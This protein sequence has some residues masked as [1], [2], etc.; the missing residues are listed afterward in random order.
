[1][2]ANSVR[3]PN[4]PCEDPSDVSA[5]PAT[6]TA[7]GTVPDEFSRGVPSLGQVVGLH[8]RLGSVP[9]EDIEID[10]LPRDDIPSVLKGPQLI[11]C[12]RGTREELLALLEAHLRSGVDRR[13]GRSGMD[14]WRI[15][16]LAVL[17]QGLGRDFDRQQELANQHLTV[18][19][20]PGRGGD[21][22][23]GFRGGRRLIM[24]SVA[25]LSPELLRRVDRRWW[26]PGT[27][28]QIGLAGRWPRGVTRPWS[29]P[30]SIG[31]PTRTCCGMRSAA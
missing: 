17:K 28:C 3:S 21:A 20:M 9:T 8:S 16:V 1:M 31:Q 23:D 11:R 14:I 30:A 18:R 22:A 4:S 25:L 24:D 7:F 19:E 6:W 13:A 26:G 12:D 2:L 27:P 29:R 15:L 5:I 10:P